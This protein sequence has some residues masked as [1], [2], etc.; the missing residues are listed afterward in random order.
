MFAAKCIG[1]VL[2][3]IAFAIFLSAQTPHVKTQT[4]YQK[5]LSTMSHLREDPTSQRQM[6]ELCDSIEVEPGDMK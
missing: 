6:Q 2:G 4:K 5:C 1:I 3:G